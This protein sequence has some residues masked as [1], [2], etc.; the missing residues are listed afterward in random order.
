MA[1]SNRDAKGSFQADISQDVID[2]ALKSVERRAQPPDS[3]EGEVPE[4]G[5]TLEMDIPEGMTLEVDVPPSVLGEGGSGSGA[6]V[7]ALMDTRQR[8]EATHRELEEARAQ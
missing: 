5:R 3:E 4:G 1:G 2:E 7:A 6:S 8:L